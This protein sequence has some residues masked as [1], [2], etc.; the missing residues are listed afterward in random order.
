MSEPCFVGIDTSNYTT[1]VAMCDREGRVIANLKRPLP[2]A[3]GGCGL[4]QSDALF[5]HVKNLPHIMGDA[6]EAMRGYTVAAIGVSSRPRDA[7]G[8]YMPCFLAGEAAAESLRT[9]VGADTPIYRF[10]HQSGHIM[11]AAYSSGK[12]DVLMSA[13]F[14]AFHVSGGTTELV[15]VKPRQ[16]GFDVTLVGGTSDLNAGQAIDR[17][18][19]AMGLKFPCGPEL[20]RL[21][22]TNTKKIPRP[23]ICVRGLE[24]NLSG[25]ENLALSLLTQTEDR[26]L[27]AAYV[28]K[29]IGETLKAMASELRA[30]YNELPL[31]FAGGVMSNGIIKDM[32]RGLGGVYFSEPAFSADN[33][34]GISLLCRAEHLSRAGG[35]RGD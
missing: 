8:S 35:G 28:L 33:A 18:G 5:A 24:C 29:F 17:V 13:Q 25:L 34:A 7:E 32:L 10:S 2:V 30:E 22:N 16:T 21:A 31:L 4:R 1:S 23:K 12:A 19:V 3:E 26:P 6:A 20:E 15:L 14:G 9:G 27:V 11:A